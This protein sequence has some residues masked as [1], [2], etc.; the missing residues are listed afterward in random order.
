LRSPTSASSKSCWSPTRVAKPRRATGFAARPFWSWRRGSGDA[1]RVTSPHAARSGRA[2]SAPGHRW[3]PLPGAGGCVSGG[4]SD[5][6]RSSVPVARRSSC[7]TLAST[8]GAEAGHGAALAPS[9]ARQ[10]ST[11]HGFA[12]EVTRLLTSR[13]RRTSGV[14]SLDRSDRPEPPAL[15]RS[16]GRTR[17][18][19]ELLRRAGEVLDL[20]VWLCSD[21]ER[22]DDASSTSRRAVDR[23]RAAER[24]DSVLQPD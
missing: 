23:D 6:S 7:A 12:L 8:S 3:R 15:V 11:G 18:R 22:D 20:L 16:S 21:R 9:P 4:A 24:L 2:A 17:G 10:R 19:P 1:S 14:T 5:S 13:S